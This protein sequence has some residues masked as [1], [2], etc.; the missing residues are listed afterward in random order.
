MKRIDFFK[1]AFVGTLGI[2]T[3]ISI[4]P[5]LNNSN[6][7]WNIKTSLNAYSFNSYLENGQM[8]LDGLIDYCSRLPFD[9]IDTTGYY[10]PGYPDVPDDK[11]I[12]HIKQKAFKNGLAISGTG[13]RNNF[14]DPD[15]KERAKDIELIKNW[16]EV[17]S[18]LGAPVIRV[19]AGRG[20]PDGYNREE[21]NSWIVDALKECVEYGKEHGVMIGMQNHNE[22]LKNADQVLEIIKLVDSDWFGMVLDVGSFATDDPY[23][24]IS[25]VAPHAVNWQI[26]ENLGYKDRVVK[27]DLRKIVDILKDINYRGYI[28]IETLGGDPKVKVPKFLNQVI[29]ALG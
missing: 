9:A 17:A 4:P 13:I 29:T 11:Y 19:F 23:T 20:T 28:P 5:L 22:Y 16:I 12:Y 1:K 14:T 7:K 24:D 18:K 8:N 10:F 2:K 25:R 6:N 3:S 21:I 26:K 27:T 15:P